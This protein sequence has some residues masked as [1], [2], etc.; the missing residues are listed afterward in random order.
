MIAPLN[1]IRYWSIP[2]F[3]GFIMIPPSVP[4]GSFIKRDLKIREL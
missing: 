4:A 1:A 2:S 3:W